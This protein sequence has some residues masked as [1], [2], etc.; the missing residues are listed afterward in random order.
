VS[1]HFNIQIGVQRVEVPE[2]RPGTAKQEREI[3]QVLSLTVTAETEPEAYVKAAKMLS[4]SA[5]TG[6]DK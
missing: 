1:T 6:D 5:P 2:H 3:L 4:A